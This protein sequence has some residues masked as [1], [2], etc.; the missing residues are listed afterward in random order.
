MTVGD[1]AAPF[2]MA[3]PSFMKHIEILTRAGLIDTA[4]EGRTRVCWIRFERF[5]RVD[6]WM[7]NQREIWE[8]RTDRLEEFVHNMTDDDHDRD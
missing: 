6:Q 2:E 7:R 3:L 5:E 4:K 1:L 8:A